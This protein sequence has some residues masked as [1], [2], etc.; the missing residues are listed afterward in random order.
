MLEARKRT[1]KVLEKAYEAGEVTEEQVLWLTALRGG[2]RFLVEEYMDTLASLSNMG[3]ILLQMKDYKGALNY[4]QE[5]LSGKEKVL[6]KTHPDILMTI[7]NM[8]TTCKRT[9]NFTKTEELYRL[10]LDGKEKSP[11][12]AHESTKKCAKNLAKLYVLSWV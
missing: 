2:G 12:K 11:W 7:M 3:G 1:P 9:E 10:A 6:G 4:Y 5:A 8:A